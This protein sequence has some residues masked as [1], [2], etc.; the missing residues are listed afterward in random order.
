MVSIVFKVIILMIVFDVWAR[1]GPISGDQTFDRDKND[2]NAFENAVHQSSPN[3]LPILRKDPPFTR[4]CKTCG[5]KET[6]N[7]GECNKPQEQLNDEEKENADGQHER[8]NPNGLEKKERPDHSKVSTEC[9]GKLRSFEELADSEPLLNL[10]G[11]ENNA[12][13][14]LIRGA[15]EFENDFDD[16]AVKERMKNIYICENHEDELVFG[17]K[18]W[19]KPSHVS[20]KRIGG[21]A[22]VQSAKCAVPNAVL[23]MH[24]LNSPSVYAKPGRFLRKKQAEAFLRQTGTHLQV[25][26]AMCKAH[27][28]QID[29]WQTVN[30]SE[31]DGL[32]VTPNVDY[33]GTASLDQPIAGYSGLTLDWAMKWLP[34]KARETQKDFFGKK[35]I[36]WHITHVLRRDPQDGKFKQRTLVHITDQDLQDADAVVAILKHVLEDLKLF[37]V[38]SIFLRSDNAGFKHSI[39]TL[40]TLQKISKETDVFI[41][42]YTFSESQAGKSSCDRMAAVVKRKLRD[43]IDQGKDVTTG[44]EFIKA[45]DSETQVNGM[46]FL[47]GQIENSGSGRK[48]K[49]PSIPKNYLS[50]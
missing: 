13:L 15:A 35:G 44:F 43:Y 33:A 39:K 27:A 19:K 3:Q 26:I 10:Y 45:M 17:W 2:G 11:A 8:L 34:K 46:K 36:S 40:G 32:E 47:F 50:Q 31:K 4:S 5:L 12:D 23:N 22:G 1:P 20:Y 48:T 16:E 41:S 30:A 7:E 25:G 49:K 37:G 14:A 29:R 21:I 28:E 38:K 9:K 24:G 42:R 18:S 6:S